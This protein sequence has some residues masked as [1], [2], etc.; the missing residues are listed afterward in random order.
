M[1]NAENP[2]QESG[3]NRFNQIVAVLIAVITLL[4]SVLTFL[5]SDASGRDNQANRDGMQYALEAF[6]KRVSGDSRVNFDYN[7]AYQSYYEYDKLALAAANRD[8]PEAEARYKSLRDKSLKLSP[9]MQPPYL[10]ADGQ[11]PDIARYEVD[12]YQVDIARLMEQFGAAS[13]V[14][15]AW[16]YKANTYIIHITLLAISLFFFGLAATIATRQ[17][18]WFFTAFGVVAAL[19]G[20]SWAATVYF[21][22]VFDLREQGKAIDQYALGVGLAYR[23]KYDEAVVA[24]DASLKDYP[25]YASAF[26]ERGHAKMA[27]GKTLEAAADFEKAIAAGDKNAATSGELAWAY[28]LLG[29]FQKSATANQ[30]ALKIA[31]DEGW[32]QFDLALTYLADGKLAEAKQEYARGMDMASSEV[33]KARQENKEPPSFVWDGM[34]DASDSLDSLIQSLDD[35]A[36]DPPAAKIADKTSARDLAVTMMGQLKSLALALEY[37]GAP[38]AGELAAKVGPFTFAEPVYNDQGE[39]TDYNVSDS[40]SDGLKEFAVDFDYTGMKD[41]SEVIFKLYI[42]GTEDPSWRIIEQWKNGAAGTAEIPISYAYSD[43]YQFG[44]GE[45]TIEVYV[46]YHLAQRGSFTIQ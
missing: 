3:D 43:T 41:G 38:P 16:D 31:P 12:L 15:L 11:A 19:W 37:T 40:F 24:F 26:K 23:E 39:I 22:P 32:I 42:D 14:K 2:T 46:D 9:M 29:D 25:A 36:A 8:D 4:A 33:V 1:T 18:R 7:V 35:G 45:Y 30:Y 27:Q 28:Y 10:N 21:Q 44:P 34:L 5:Q 17:T 13:E 20:V 6:D